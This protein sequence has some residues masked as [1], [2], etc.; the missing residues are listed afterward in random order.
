MSKRVA[1]RKKRTTRKK[2]VPKERIIF[3][4]NL[5]AARKA[6]GQTQGQMGRI[7][8]LAQPFISDLENGKTTVSLDNA[9]YLADALGLPL[10]KL[11]MP[12]PQDLE[13]EAKP[14]GPEAGRGGA[15]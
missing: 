10:Y 3:A 6:A 1:G 7:A 15:Q 9:A 14:S 5:Q 4:R 12:Y 13:S 8:G 2:P 11:L